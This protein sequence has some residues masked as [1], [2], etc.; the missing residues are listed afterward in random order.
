MRRAFDIEPTPLE[1]A[2]AFVGWNSHDQAMFLANVH[3]LMMQWGAHNK[4]MQVLGIGTALR[5][6]WPDAAQM[7]RELADDTEGA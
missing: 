7:V 2:E 4:D 5:D 1:A 3:R 6:C